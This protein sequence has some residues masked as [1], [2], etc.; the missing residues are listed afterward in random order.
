MNSLF[1]INWSEQPNRFS[2]N[3][4]E[5]KPK[6]FQFSSL[7]LI[8]IVQHIHSPVSKMYRITLADIGT[9]NLYFNPI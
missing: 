2:F 8:E 9:G 4:G 5:E 3:T 7:T 1:H 6:L